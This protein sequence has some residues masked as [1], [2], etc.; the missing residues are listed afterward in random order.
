MPRISGIIL[1]IDCNRENQFI[2]LFDSD[3][4]NKALLSHHLIISILMMTIFCLSRDNLRAR[5]D[6]LKV[7]IF[8]EALR[9]LSNNFHLIYYHHR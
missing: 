6:I 5:Y 4:P 9:L 7:F 3:K 8:I 2:R 1:P